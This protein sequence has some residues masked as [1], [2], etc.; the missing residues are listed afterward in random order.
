M[1]TA[2]S[3]RPAAG[4]ESLNGLHWAG[5]VSAAVSAAVHLLLGV[6]MVP[7]P[8]GISFVFAGLGFVGGIV[9]VVRGYRR[10]TVYAV[11]IAFTLV[12]I[13]LWYVVNFAGGGRSFPADVGTLGAVDKVAQVVLIAVLAALLRR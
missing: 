4:I 5:I 11:G 3:R 7:S 6:R 10:R 13:V 12:Q 9:L 1:A 8:L 2:G